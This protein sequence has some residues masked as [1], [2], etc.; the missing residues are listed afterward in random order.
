MYKDSFNENQD[1]RDIRDD[2]SDEMVGLIEK[3]PSHTAP[4]EDILLNDLWRQAKMTAE[5]SPRARFTFCEILHTAIETYGVI[6]RQDLQEEFPVFTTDMLRRP[7][8]VSDN[9][10]CPDVNTQKNI[11]NFIS[12]L[13]FSTAHGSKLPWRHR[14][15]DQTEAA[16][17]FPNSQHTAKAHPSRTP[18]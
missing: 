8:L 2:T 17:V 16:P 13:D 11:L 3:T 10:V 15:S 7:N 5:Q 6:S 9:P 18:A 1:W 14:K 4:P 12:T